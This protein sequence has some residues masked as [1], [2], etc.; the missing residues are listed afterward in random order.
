MNLVVI[1]FLISSY[2]VSVI[3]VCV[4]KFSLV[5]L[6]VVIAIIAILSSLLLTSLSNAK[7]SAKVA[8]CSSNQRQIGTAIVSYSSHHD[9]IWPFSPQVRAELVSAPIP[10]GSKLPAEVIWSEVGESKEIFICPIDPEPEVFNWWSFKSR[11][12]FIDDDAKHSYM[13]NEWAAWAKAR[14]LGSVY[15]VSETETPSEWPQISDGEHAISSGVWNRCNPTNVGQYGVME[16]WH[17]KEKVN[18]LLGDGHIE[19][20]NAY[21]IELLDPH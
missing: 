12:Y 15:R 7:N 6:L 21:Y 11:K 4:R 10:S 17:P 8:V 13:F 9:S 19:N 14:Y 2:Y 5:E 18:V 1:I 20:K 16:W 3:M